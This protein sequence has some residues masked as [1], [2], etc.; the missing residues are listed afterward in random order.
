MRVSISRAWSLS[1]MALALSL[2]ATSNLGAQCPTGTSIANFRYVDATSTTPR[3]VT[4]AWDAPAGA[5]EGTIYEVM[6]S[7]S[8][9][10]CFPSSSYD[11]VEETTATLETVTL[12]TSGVVYQFYVRVKGCPQVSTPGTWVDDSF[13]VPPTA[14]LLAAVASASGQVDATL[15][16][17]DSRTAVQVLERAGADGVFRAADINYYY[18][19]CP[20]GSPKTF[21]DSGLA[22]GTYTYRAWALNQ[23]TSRR[24]YSEVV[25][26]TVVGGTCTLG[27]SAVVPAAAPAGTPITFRATTATAGCAG[28]ATVSWSFGDGTISTVTNAVHTYASPGIYSWALTASLEGAAPCLRTGV[29]TIARAL[30]AIEF[31]T[32]SSTAIETGGSTTLSWAT[33]GASD[34]RIEPGVGGV[35]GTG[36]IDVSPL[37][38]TTYSL[39]AT[40]PSGTTV[41]RLQIV[42]RASAGTAPRSTLVTV[43]SAPGL[44]G[45]FYR[46]DVQL[47]NPSTSSVYGRLI[48]HPKE[49]SGSDSDPTLVYA[50]APG[51][52]FDYRDLLTIHGVS[53]NGSLDVV[54]DS[55]ALP[56][57]RARVFDSGGLLGTTGASEDARY[58][59]DALVAGD[60]GVLLAPADPRSYRFSI[61]LRTLASG[62]TLT[63][64]L[65]SASG[66]PLK[67]ITRSY[68]PHYYMQASSEAFLEGAVLQGNESVTV[69]VQAGSAF[70]YGTVA[71]NTTNDPSIQ[72]ADRLP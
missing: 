43:V 6:G 52:T 53:G 3:Q 17:D 15:T 60:L 68:A 50:L 64:V 14:P 12:N 71:D 63:F 59:G 45:A 24:V 18:D 10:Y 56:M 49:T 1:G 25:P 47:N 46:T 55:G 37:Q 44:H 33:S 26:V 51:Q 21:Q 11:V 30:P 54:A 9:D 16:Q 67:T 35:N 2:L 72:F 66:V 20:A 42:V 36:Y 8:P 39:F 7:T 31:F 5:A 4:Y 19:I 34:V 62:A 28:A 13:Q 29:L 40:S 65:K 57:A 41:R 70:V 23:G 38:T 61:G 27:C 48:Y 58:E 22:T 32:A 69:S